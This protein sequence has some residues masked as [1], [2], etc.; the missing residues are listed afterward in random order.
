MAEVVGVGQCSLDMLGTVEPWPEPDSK[1]ELPELVVQG[2]GP[3][4]TAMV[5]LS[6]LGISTALQGAV[7]SD[8]AG[9]QIRAGLELE[10]VD[11]SRLLTFEGRRS[12]TAFIAVDPGTAQRTVF[13][14]RGDARITPEH[15]DVQQIRQARVLHLDGL[16]LDVAMHAARIARQHGVAT[17]LDGGTLRSG[18][19][20]LLPF[21]DHAV[22]SEHFAQTLCPGDP[23]AA[24]ER[25]LGYGVTAATVT[26]GERGSVTRLRTGHE[27]RQ[28]AYKVDVVDT[29][30]CGDV[31]HGAYIYTL[32]QEWPWQTKLA[33]AAACAALK[34]RSI[35]G[36]SG[37]PVY[38]AVAGFLAGQG[39]ALPLEQ[40]SSP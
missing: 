40:E 29:T 18:V 36:R 35:G 33:F 10:E 7:G 8:D 11:C 1:V 22:V 4:A 21:I 24:C 16:H 9:R 19:K 15:L 2:G 37:I 28:P 38:E 30:G 25:L 12:Q 13:W 5:T 6:R 26:L 34:A 17:V 32:L 14:H 3:V 31:F 27:Y 23:S 20:R 39:V